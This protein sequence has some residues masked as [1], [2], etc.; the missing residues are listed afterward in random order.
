MTDDLSEFGCPDCGVAIGQLHADNCDIEQCP[1][2]GLQMLGCDCI[3]EVNGINIW[4]AEGKHFDPYKENIT[5]QMLKVWNKKW[6]SKREPW[7]GIYPG[8]EEGGE[9]FELAKK[10]KRAQEKMMKK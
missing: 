7:S 5:E 4:S 10:L 1:R 9:L 2:C 8:T 3:Y 6:G